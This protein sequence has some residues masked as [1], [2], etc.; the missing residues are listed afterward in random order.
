VNDRYQCWYVSRGKYLRCGFIHV[1][2]TVGV[3]MD[4]VLDEIALVGAMYGDDVVVTDYHQ[5]QRIDMTVDLGGDFAM[6]IEVPYTKYPHSAKPG[7]TITKGV[8]VVINGELER[9]VQRLATEMPLDQPLLA[10]IIGAAK[11]EVA[12]ILDAIAAEEAAVNAAMAQRKIAAAEAEA[13]AKDDDD[14]RYLREHNIYCGE[15]IYDRK[16]KFVAHVARTTSA[17]RV[18]DVVNV[19]RQQ[20]KI[21]CAAHPAIYA[22]RF[23]DANGLLHAD[24]DDDGETGAARKMMFL[25]EQLRAENCVVIVTR[26]FGGILLGPD[27]FKHIAAVT[28]SAL[29]GSGVVR[30]ST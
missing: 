11:A 4:E 30:E 16:S 14:P 9:H 19:L 17:Q 23:T 27:R 12:D 5:C 18:R 1:L 13:A 7:I 29:I 3:N 25:M 2:H 15:A 20:S 8:N 10:D 6:R 28:R 26:W 22:Y 21:A 24:C